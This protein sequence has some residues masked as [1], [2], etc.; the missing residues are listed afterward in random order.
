MKDTVIYFYGYQNGVMEKLYVDLG[1]ATLADLISIKNSF[2]S[3]FSET[4]LILENIILNSINPHYEKMNNKIKR[5]KKN[6]RRFRQK[7]EGNNDKY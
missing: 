6:C 1:N 2:K 4:S 3:N 5:R 7:M